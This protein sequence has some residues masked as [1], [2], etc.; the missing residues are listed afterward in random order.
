M[1][2]EL[3]HVTPN[4]EELIVKMARVSAPENESNM[5]TAPRLLRYLLKHSHVSPFE[6]ANMCVAINTT[7]GISAQIIR[8]RSFSFQ[9]F[10]LA[11]NARITVSNGAGGVQRLSIEE[12]HEKWSSPAFKTRYARSYD[13]SVERFIEAPILSVYESGE[14]PV[15]RFSINGPASVKTID[16][17]REHRVLTKERGFVPFGE[18]FDN[19]LTVALNGSTA[20]PLPYQD[21][22]VL[23]SH[24]W[25]GSTRFAEEFNI[26]PITARKWFHKHGITPYNPNSAPCSKIN[27]S[28]TAKKSSFMKW[29]RETVR[30]N[31]CE[32]CGHDG[33]KSRL[34]LS[35]ITAHDGNPLLCF[36]ENNLQTLCAKCHR[37]YDIN[38]QGKNYGWTLAMTAKWGKI[39]NQ[40]FLGIQKTYDIEMDHPTHNFVADGVVVHNSQRYADVAAMGSPE[41]PQLRRQDLKN[42]QNSIDDLTA[43]EKG[44]YYRRIC[45]IF[46]DS[47]HLYREMVSNGVAKECARNVLPLASR[48]RIYMNGTLRSWIH[49]IQLRESHGTQMEHQIIAKEIKAIFTEQF[50]IIA[51]AA[52]DVLP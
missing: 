16:C 32:S 51:E 45:Q 19:E 39:I 9:E 41:V 27:V 2:V 3:V 12:L 35:H 4:A 46:E 18:A 50:P 38:V 44:A 1:T 13:V 48:T 47:E 22:E 11:G 43:D 25:M 36:D 28:F 26:K 37:K 15:Y 17:T 21:P 30:K 14:K 52:F 6:M 8:H 40:E 33:S 42:R 24:A 5:E 34:E 49:Y 7:R 29:A 31:I 20:K 10:C 23:Q